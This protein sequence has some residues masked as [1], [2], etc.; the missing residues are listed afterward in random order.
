VAEQGRVGLSRRSPA[1]A[2]EGGSGGA[3]RVLAKAGIADFAPFPPLATSAKDAWNRLSP[4]RLN[5]R[6]A[7]GFQGTF[8]RLELANP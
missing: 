7:R 6:D 3:F 8:N 2:G 5:R 1:A 4:R